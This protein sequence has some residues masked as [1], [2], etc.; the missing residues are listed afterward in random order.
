MDADKHEG[1]IENIYMK[2]L[3]GGLE[4]LSIGHWPCSSHRLLGGKAMR[5]GAAC[6]YVKRAFRAGCRQNDENLGLALFGIIC[7]G[8]GDARLAL[9]LSRGLCNQGRPSCTHRLDT[10]SCSTWPGRLC[11]VDTAALALLALLE[12]EQAAG[13]VAGAV[14][15]R[16]RTRAPFCLAK[17][18]STV[19]EWS[20]K[21]AM[22]ICCHFGWRAMPVVNVLFSWGCVVRFW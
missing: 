11:I 15:R 20:R 21:Q 18:S 17:R 10:L 3:A 19:W 6:S 2:G 8:L 14:A 1:G 22:L 16:P 12:L 13:A 4:A 7:D 9:H 5:D